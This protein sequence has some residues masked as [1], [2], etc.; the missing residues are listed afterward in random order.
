MGDGSRARRSGKAIGNLELLCWGVVGNGACTHLFGAQPDG[1]AGGRY[2]VNV[3]VD[4]V[5]L[6]VRVDGHQSA[7]VLGATGGLG[8]L[9][10][11]QLVHVLQ[12][13]PASKP[14]PAVRTRIFVLDCNDIF[15]RD[16]FQ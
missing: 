10:V 12:T 16:E 2:G 9:I 14:S 4:E 7:L 13:F 15:E 11:L 3:G 8:P 5:L 1:R 6:F